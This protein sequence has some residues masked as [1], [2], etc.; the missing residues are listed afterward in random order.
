MRDGYE[1]PKSSSVNVEPARRCQTH[2]A[3][4]R[5]FCHESG[6]Y[7]AQVGLIPIKLRAQCRSPPA[8]GRIQITADSVATLLRQFH[9]PEAPRGNMRLQQQ[10]VEPRSRRHYRMAGGR[11]KSAGTDR[12]KSSIA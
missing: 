12:G 8:G 6:A 2:S 4:K 10:A 7:I 11:K 3:P 9:A 5:S 1:Q